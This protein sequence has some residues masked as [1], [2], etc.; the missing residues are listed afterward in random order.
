V[1]FLLAL[2]LACVLCSTAFAAESA[3]SRTWVVALDGTGQFRSIQ[4]AVDQAANGDTIE[5]RAGDYQEDVTIHSKQHLRLIGDRGGRVRVLGRSRVGSFHIGKWPY[6]ASDITVSGITIESHGG[7]AMGI[8]NGRS[9]VLRQVRINGLLFSQQAA[10]VRIEDCVIGDSETT[11][12]AF[13]D[14][15]GVLVGNLIHDNDHGITIAGKSDVRLE[16]N[17]IVRS[18]Y[19]GVVISDKS[20][21]ALLSNTI[22]K[23]GTGAAFTGQSEGEASGNILAL[24]RVGFRVEP[25]SRAGLA[26]NAVFNTEHD[27]EHPGGAALPHASDVR[28]DP[29]FV[30]AERGD[31]RLKSDTPLRKR[32]DFGYLG[33]LPPLG[34]P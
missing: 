11:G 5:I 6:G 31:F 18:L 3:P 9:L 25:P 34:A 29:H 19:D 23:N 12:V 33:A 13:A 16:R 20:R 15:Q 7:L 27:Y 17:V 22:V 30:D 8:F 4:E 2:A 21:G 24:N 1:R 26:H 14:S 28:L 32:G 10:D